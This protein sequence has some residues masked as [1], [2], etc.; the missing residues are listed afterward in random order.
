MSFT[1]QRSA[2]AQKATVAVFFIQGFVAT[3]QIPR[4]PEIIEQIGVDFTTWGLIMGLSI[5][6]G[7]LGL[8]FTSRLIAKNGT[9]KIAIL[10]GLGLTVMLSSIGFITNPVV[11]FVVQFATAFMFSIFNI[12]INSQTVALQKALNKIIIGKFHAAWSI[13]AAGA[14]AV[15][16][17]LSTFMPVWQHMLFFAI[18]SAA[19]FAYFS[20]TLLSNEEDGHGQ[21]KPAKKPVSFLKSPTQV[22][23][24][25][26]GLFTGVLME[27]TLQ[28]WSS[29]F[30]QQ[31]LG[32]GTGKAA[33]P[34]TAFT[35][36][37]I[38]GRLLI[39]PLSKIWHLSK[40]AQVG[41]LAGGISM[42]LAILIGVPLTTTNPDLALL[43]V[44]IFFAITGLGIAPV[45][46][47]FFSLAGSVKGLNTAQVLAR[48][49]MVN[50]AAI[51]LAK[52]L[53]GA[54]AD[55]FGVSSTLLFGA[56]GLFVS[57]VLAGVMAKSAKRRSHESAYPATGSMSI[58]GD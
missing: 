13:G 43:T 11:F 39:N 3:T 47:S 36:T 20:R 49:S 46:P 10:G 25:A 51:V 24:L 38:M 53:L 32:Q 58:V 40:I 8:I 35:I 27:V 14:S 22:W 1:Q 26:A 29:V 19:V 37:M 33:I 4:I 28:D 18:F 41:G 31:A 17:L 45:V 30:G 55:G 44:T 16:A 42:A 52:I 54:S 9:K 23:L 15:G 2:Q 56:V 48:M 50:T 5:L 7:V 34:F 57:G 12:S 21:G 6:G